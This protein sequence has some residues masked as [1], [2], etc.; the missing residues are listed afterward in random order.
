MQNSSHLVAA[1]A[2]SSSDAR[3]TPQTSFNGIFQVS[4]SQVTT[5]LFASTFDPLSAPL[6]SILHI[7]ISK[8]SHDN[9]GTFQQKK[10]EIGNNSNIASQ[11]AA[12]SEKIG[13]KHQHHNHFKGAVDPDWLEK[14][15]QRVKTNDMILETIDENQDSFIPMPTVLLTYL[16]DTV[17]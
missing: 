14:I 10:T 2:P 17:S 4:S 12:P 11:M 1:K 5:P 15:I 9:R 16:L 6:C 13:K 7:K 3:K 8:T